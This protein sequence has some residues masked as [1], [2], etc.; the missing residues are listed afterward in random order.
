MR[1]VPRRRR[2]TRSP[3]AALLLVLLCVAAG[4]IA[5][6]SR[7]ADSAR[8]SASTSPV[9]A[10]VPCAP[11]SPN[12]DAPPGEKPSRWFHGNG[13][14][15]TV[16]WPRGTVVFA[17]GGPGEIR[18]D[19]SL[20][21]KFPFWRGA[22]VTGELEITGRSLEGADEPMTG[23]ATAGYGD[24]GFQASTLI[25]PGPGCWEVTA[26]VGQVRLTFVTRVV[27]RQ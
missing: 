19:E 21:M 1:A 3:V 4:A 8:T 25:F 24:R 11:T 12:G 5:G 27:R 18:A 13:K 16:L 26:R 15:W 20:A 23:E 7:R 2:T 17:P 9:A 6:C 14:I 10:A 22:G